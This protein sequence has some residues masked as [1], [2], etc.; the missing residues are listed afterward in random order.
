MENYLTIGQAAE[1]LAVDHKTIRRMLVRLG[2]V[3]VAE[4]G[5]K[6]RL[7][8]IPEESLER[9]LRGCEIKPQTTAT[10]AKEATF[11]FERRRV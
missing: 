8:R 9:F 1:K 6:R 2:A 7:I 4:P 5:A 10:R 3:N 11:H